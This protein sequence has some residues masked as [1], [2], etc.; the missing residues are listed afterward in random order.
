MPASLTL[1]NARD[2]ARLIA[3]DTAT[4]APGVSD[5]KVNSLIEEARQWYAS[6]FPEDMLA[7]AY[8]ES[9]SAVTTS[10]ALTTTNTFRS[11]DTCFCTDTGTLYDKVDYYLLVQKSQKDTQ[12]SVPASDIASWGC[13]RDPV[14][15]NKWNL[16]FYPTAA[17]ARKIRIYGHYEV[18]P[19]TGDSDVLLFGHHGS[20]VIAR[21]AAIEVAR[22]CGRPTDF[23]ASI[24]AN[25]PD[26]VMTRRDD[27]KRMLAN[28]AMRT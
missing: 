8:N 5:A 21:L 12:A 19:L 4:T 7:L 9:S 25:L 17:V 6:T 20:R 1:A 11:L 27:L 10:L 13:V 18:V 15:D 14:T 26:R 28:H 3:Q 23:L 24:A 2:L 22:L 16:I